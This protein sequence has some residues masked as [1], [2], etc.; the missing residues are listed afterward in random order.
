MTEGA[1][2]RVAVVYDC[3]FPYTTGGGERV[4]TE[5]AARF[6]ERGHRVDYLTRVQWEGE[7]PSGLP[8]RV[9]P[10]W[11]GPIADASGTRLTSSA[12]RFAAA[13][14][15]RLRRTRRDYD[16]VVV[17]ALPSLNVFAARAALGRRGPWLLADWLEVWPARKWREYSGA[18]VGTV[19]HVLQAVGLRRS[20]DVSVN[21]A[22]TLGRARPRL[23]PGNGFV[24]GLVDLAGAPRTAAEAVE[25]GLVLFAGRHIPDKQVTV[26]P[27]ALAAL[28]RRNPAAR[29]V[30]T[31]TGPETP[32][33]VAAIE[34]TGAPV[35]LRGRVPDDELE[36]LMSRAAVLVNPSRREGFGL[37]VAEAAAHGTP[38][39]VVAGEDNAA[40]ELIVP[41]VNGFVAESTDP[42]VL[43][44]ALGRAL[45]GGEELRATTSAWFD[46]AR[47]TN[48][49]DASLDEILR[50]YESASTR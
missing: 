49:L 8:F 12:V 3:L 30:V 26:L 20:D 46:D 40:A 9:V 48:S 43:A 13:V 39:V 45:D 35:E 5:L 19:A 21:S 28:R 4:Y 2:L 33:L 41:G 29:L 27:A 14:F 24:L 15:Q 16:I 7:V 6:A 47:R 11:D 50:R 17:S 42:E 44:E 25:P 36:S 18:A 34:A 31:G 32:A 10:I 37:V 1:P 38:S 23:R 22:F